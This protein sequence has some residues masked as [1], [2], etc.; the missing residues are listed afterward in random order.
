[1]STHSPHTQL[2]IG[3]DENGLG[4]RLGPMLV[5]AVMARVDD[6]GR[7][8]LDRA[9]PRTI[10]RDLDD[11]KRLVSFGKHGVGEAWARALYPSAQSPAEL[12]AMASARG[13][14]ELQS[15]CPSSAVRQCWTVGTEA[16][17]ADPLLV[18]RVQRHL[19][20]LRKR[21]VHVLTARSLP[22]CVGRLNGLRDEGI[23]RFGADLHAME[24]LVLDLREEA[25]DEVHA[26]CGKVGGITDYPSYFGPLSG[27]LHVVLEQ[28]RPRSSY[29]FPGLG[30]LDFV[31][32][33]DASDPLVMLASLVGKYLRELLMS[34]ISRFYTGQIEG[35]R[36]ASGYHDPVT[37]QLV[38]L[39]A[40]K[41]KK[42]R[43]PLRCFERS[44]ER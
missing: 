19:S 42:L 17:G 25:G 39:T 29:R 28:S 16:F 2:R 36:D 8:T 20:S 35:L 6:G 14:T 24:A 21:G 12:L 9:L 18:Q 1:M 33:A 27:R 37:D 26:V 11:S 30:Q 32:D 34:R 41:R 3:A 7:R 44:S 4:A 15:A 13:L 38:R 23:T 31:Q 10:A 5:T 22:V 40:S 43:I